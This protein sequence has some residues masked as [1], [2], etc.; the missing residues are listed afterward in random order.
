MKKLL[1]CLLI[2]ECIAFI[3]EGQSTWIQRF[4]GI[5]AYPYMHNDSVCG[6]QKIAESPDGKLYLQVKQYQNYNISLFKYDPV[7]KTILWSQQDIGYLSGF[8][9]YEPAGLFSTSD[10]GCIIAVTHMGWSVNYHSGVE[11]TKYS[12]NGVIQWNFWLVDS[13]ET[14]CY[15]ADDIIENSS[16]NY[17]VL[18]HDYC[19]SNK[20]SL[21]ELD[22]SGNLIFVTGAIHG[23]KLYELAPNNLIVYNGGAPFDTIYRTDLSGNISW[24]FSEQT[25]LIG[26]WWPLEKHT[27]ISFGATGIFKC[28]SDTV[29]SW[30]TI[31]KIDYS[32]GNV[33]W[34]DTINDWRVSGIDATADGGVLVSVG[35]RMNGI[36]QYPMNGYLY[37]I[38]SAGTILWQKTCSFP[39]F[40]LSAIKE[41]SSGNYIT[42]GTYILNQYWSPG[43][44]YASF[45]TMIDSAGN[46]VLDTTSNMWPGDANHNDTLYFPEDVLFMAIGLGKTGF[47]RDTFPVGSF[48]IWP[49][50]QSDYAIDWSQSFANGVNLK[51]ADYNGDGVIDTADIN[52]YLASSGLLIYPEPIHYRNVSFSSIPGTAD[53]MLL[54]EKDTVAPGEI[55]RFYIVAGNSSAPV[56]SVYG[57][58]FTAWYDDALTDTSFSN[59]SITNSDFGI[60]GTNLLGAFSH[61]PGG[62]IDMVIS[63]TD[64]MNAYLLYDTLGIIELKAAS[65][66][67][68][69]Q[70]FDLQIMSFYSL[71]NNTSRVAFNPV[72]G[73]VVI[74]PGLVNLEEN[75]SGSGINIFPNPVKD[76]IKIQSSNLKIEKIEIVN[77]HGKI[78][79]AE[80]FSG[81]KNVEL[82]TGNLADGF[83]SL[84][85][86]SEKKTGNL[87][88]IK[89][90]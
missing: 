62:E 81:R 90:N 61:K 53:F 38:D 9:G 57:I 16:G 25:D 22:S 73:L 78:I 45:V 58:A 50:D 86:Y 71:T 33:L 66:I 43:R 46:G 51:H 72:N 41:L 30:T 76:K 14:I 80:S 7:S 83:Y 20:D 13:T 17:Y 60:P 44:Q 70:T 56:D 4:S 11:V 35:S 47:P 63:K 1:F 10:S 5:G 85:I 55:M 48:I 89:I 8:T 42:G 6:V 37:K 49:W 23:E 36:S 52:L 28:H 32:T 79:Y 64:N 27:N 87:K 21:Y 29:L 77:L 65:A 18:A 39:Y 3:C 82:Y 2:T 68:T 88:F 67:T 26:N 12:K 54:P 31:K 19:G 24:T 75:N 84:K 34:T 74:D 69:L 59:I 40:G 15:V